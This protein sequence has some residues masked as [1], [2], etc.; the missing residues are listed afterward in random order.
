[1]TSPFALTRTVCRV[2]LPQ[3]SFSRKTHSQLEHR[4][5]INLWPFSWLNSLMDS[6]ETTLGKRSSPARSTPEIDE[7]GQ[8]A[9]RLSSEQAGPSTAEEDTKMSDGEG[10][11]KEQRGT[12]RATRG[13]GKERVPKKRRGTRPDNEPREDGAE[14]APR[15]P[16]KQCAL[17]LGF[18]GTRYSG[19]QMCVGK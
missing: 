19:M 17:L 15:L 16:K 6:S 11:T 3:P 2:K 7:P 8:K 1:M 13:K 4:R 12:N 18:A 5:S 10:E 9:P 14:R